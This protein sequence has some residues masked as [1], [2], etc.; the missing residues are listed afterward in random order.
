MNNLQTTYNIFLRL[1][2]TS[3]YYRVKH[4]SLKMLQLLY[5]SLM[6]KLSIP[7]SKNKSLNA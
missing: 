6:I 7:P 1:L 4:K 5:H 2:K 3:P